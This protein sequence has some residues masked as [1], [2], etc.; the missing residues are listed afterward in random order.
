MATENMTKEELMEDFKEA[1][2]E[3]AQECAEEGYPSHGSTYELRCSALWY[4]YY[5]DALENA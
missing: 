1:C 4:D 5:M 3:I 2:V